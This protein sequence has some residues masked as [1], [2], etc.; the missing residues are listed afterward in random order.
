LRLVEAL[1]E[2]GFGV[3]LASGGMPHPAMAP[4][5]AEIVQLPPIRTRGSDFA[6]LAD[7]AGRPVD[8]ALRRARCRAL[9]DA[10]AGVR[11]DAVVIEAFPFGRRAFRFEL[12]ALIAAA[13]ARRPRAV[14]LCSLRDIVVA[15]KEPWRRHDIIARVRADFDA[16]LVHGDPAFIPLEASF[17]EAVQIADSLVYTGYVG[18]TL[19]PDGSARNKNGGGGDVLVS[20]GGGAVGGALLATALEARRLGCL[21]DLGWRL[22]AGPNLPLAQFAA[23]AERLPEGVVLERYRG[24]FPDLLRGCRVS[25]S[26]AGYN[27]VLDILAAR[28]AAVVVPF[29]AGRETE[30]R[31]RAERLAAKGVLDM[32]DERDLSPGRL[33]KAVERA[34]AAPRTALSVDTGGASRTARV[35]AAMI[36]GDGSAVHRFATPRAKHMI[37]R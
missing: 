9:L 17:P 3:V 19:P 29:A 23:L 36:N 6:D 1:A 18:R 27:T 10:F 14:V 21:A 30:Q 11:P 16:V 12:D 7:A 37:A 31:L 28:A 34:V 22:L 20:A 13:R 33:A 2:D 26:Q 35:L 4:A 5:A 32:V 24:D 15:P 25:I 8:D